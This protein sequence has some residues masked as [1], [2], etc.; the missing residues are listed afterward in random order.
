MKRWQIY[1]ADVPFE[2]DPTQRKRR[3]VLIAKDCVAFVLS[4]KITSHGAR[5]YDP[6][7]Y[8][9]CFWKEAGLNSQSTVRISKLTKLNR[10]DFCGYIG[11][12]HPAD[13]LA[14]LDVMA[15]YRNDNMK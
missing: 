14:L 8:E 10:E 7:D 2:D 11:E 6:Y 12:L 15:R 1:W 13:V 9:I 5:E 4:F 3:P